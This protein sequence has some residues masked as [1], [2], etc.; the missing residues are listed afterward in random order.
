[1]I[2]ARVF[3]L[4]ESCICGF[5]IIWLG[6]KNP[7]YHNLKLRFSIVYRIQFLRS[8]ADIPYTFAPLC[9][10]RL[11]LFFRHLKQLRARSKILYIFGWN[12]ALRSQ[13]R[14]IWIHLPRVNHKTM[15]L[16]QNALAEATEYLLIHLMI[17]R[18][19]ELF[20]RDSF[21]NLL[22]TNRL[23]FMMGQYYW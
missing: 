6:K 19:G 10:F 1:M 17:W 8:A 13:R 15:C 22:H 7:I 12:I 16:E 18:V 5:Y 20:V 9:F 11:G 23:Y 14:W 2:S 21:A 4:Y 3:L